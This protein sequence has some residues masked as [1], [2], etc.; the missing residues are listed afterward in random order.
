MARDEKQDIINKKLNLILSR[1]NFLATI[2]IGTGFDFKR[3]E[4]LKKKWD[5]LSRRI[6]GEEYGDNNSA[7]QD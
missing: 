2:I 6:M 7:K 4:A 3:Q 5:N 1:Q